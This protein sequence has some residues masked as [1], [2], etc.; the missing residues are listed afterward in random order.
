MALAV[1]SWGGHHGAA[2]SAAYDYARD[3]RKCSKVLEFRLDRISGGDRVRANSGSSSD[4]DDLKEYIL[5]TI[6]RL[7][8]LAERL[9]DYAEEQNPDGDQDDTAV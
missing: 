9:E 2:G 1:G 6:R 8:R 7:E 4:D 5:G 3:L